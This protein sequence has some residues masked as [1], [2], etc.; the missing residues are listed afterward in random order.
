MNESVFK[1]NATTNGLGF[2]ASVG[3]GYNEK[4][5]SFSSLKKAMN[6]IVRVRKD[7]TSSKP[8]NVLFIHAHVH[9]IEQCLDKLDRSN[10]IEI[11]N[12]QVEFICKVSEMNGL[13]RKEKIKRFV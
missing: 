10:I 2:L 13:L 4:G 12:E 7:L 6:H 3:S 1:V 9:Q 8:T 11:V 5:L